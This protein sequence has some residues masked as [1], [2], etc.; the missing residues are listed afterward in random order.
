MLE[1]QLLGM[2]FLTLF[3]GAMASSRRP[4]HKR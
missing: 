2:G 3:F 1:F 4:V